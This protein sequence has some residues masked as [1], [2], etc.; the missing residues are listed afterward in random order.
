MMTALL[1]GVTVTVDGCTW[2]VDTTVPA[3]F[4][5]GLAVIEYVPAGSASGVVVPG[6][7]VSTWTWVPCVKYRVWAD[8]YRRSSGAE[9][10]CTLTM[11]LVSGRV[12]AASAKD[13]R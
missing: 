5:S 9:L 10:A 11:P 1:P 12:S 2:A 3:W 7:T 4:D 13:D 6:A 8:E